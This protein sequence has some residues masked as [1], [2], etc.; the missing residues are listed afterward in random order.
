MAREIE[1]KFTGT[2]EALEKLRRSK[3]L[4]SHTQGRARTS[5][6][7]STYFDTSAQDLA[8]RGVSLRIRKD[9]AKLTQ[10]VK[11]LNGK[12]APK[13]DRAEQ[14]A[15]VVSLQPEPGVIANAHVRKQLTDWM[16]RGE[17][18][19]M[20]ETDFKRTAIPLAANGSKIEAA[21]DF[22]QIRA[23]GLRDGVNTKLAE[24]ELELKE[25]HEQALFDL[26]REVT[27]MAPVR[28]AIETKADRGYALSQG[29]GDKAVRAR[30]LTLEKDM[31]ATD[32]FALILGEGLRQI[33][34]NENA[35]L[36]ARDVEGVHQ[37]RVA[38]RRLR[39][40]LSA[41]GK[42]Y[43]HG[44]MA[45]I[46]VE[47]AWLAG[48]LGAAR[49]WD[50]FQARI[51]RPVAE[52]FPGDFGLEALTEA[53]RKA[54]RAAWDHV[55]G[56]VEGERYRVLMVDI[57]AAISGRTWE[58]K[59]IADDARLRGKPSPYARPIEKVAQKCL[60]KRLSRATALGERI[61]ELSVAERH[62]LRILLKRLRYAADFLQSCFPDR[63]A[64]KYLGALTRLQDIFGE[65]N[66]AAMAEGLIEKLTAGDAEPRALLRAGGIVTGWH[67]ALSAK[68]WA[69]ARKRWRKFQSVKRFWR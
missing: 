68:L 51:L 4:K 19:A 57:A 67:M 22:G 66:D 23:L 61:E 54:R 46:K 34:A 37:M 62:E 15:P 6:L 50:V 1:L 49:D 48:E 9:G 42:A 56:E 14:D 36:R 41:F 40:A 20:F 64:H 47:L 60:D 69:S 44:E 43:G 21:F 7:K 2:V 38:I 25:G 58:D 52:A 8:Q 63:A 24:L 31:P 29:W 16:E 55:L 45:R 18:R 33:I 12:T 53:A 30:P 10:T 11:S 17:L 59:A 26:A 13:W 32:A 39:S 5:D 35:I 28:F 3:L 27:K 65:L